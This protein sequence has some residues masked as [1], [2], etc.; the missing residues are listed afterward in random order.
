MHIGD[1]LGYAAAHR[2]LSD[3]LRALPPFPDAPDARCLLLSGPER[4]GKT[5]LLF[6]AALSLARQGAS[7]LLLCRR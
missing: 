1:F 2:A 6:H 3:Q 4:S 5:S 7:V